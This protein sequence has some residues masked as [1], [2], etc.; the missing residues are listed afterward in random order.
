MSRPGIEHNDHKLLTLKKN[1]RKCK[2][3]M[4]FSKKIKVTNAN[5]D[6]ESRPR[7]GRKLQ[8]QVDVDENSGAG[9]D[10]NSRCH[11]A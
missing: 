5:P 8:H 10:G 9:Q 2:N 7:E 11:E 4:K 6:S 1:A 3:I